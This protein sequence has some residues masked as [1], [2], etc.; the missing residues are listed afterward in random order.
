MKDDKKKKFRSHGEIDLHEPEELEETEGAPELPKKAARADDEPSEEAD[1]SPAETAGG[2]DENAPPEDDH[3]LADKQ[4]EQERVEKFFASGDGDDGQPPE[5]PKEPPYSGVPFWKKLPI[6]YWRHRRWT[7]PLTMLIILVVLAAI[8]AVRYSVLSHYV[9]K[10]YTVHVADRQTGRPVE[11]AT[12]RLGNDTDSTD[13][14]GDVQVAAKVGQRHLTINRKYYHNFSTQVFVNLLGN[15]N[16]RNIKLAATGRQVPFTV[17]D[18]L[19]GQPIKNATI[20]VL[21]TSGETDKNGKAVIVLPAKNLTLRAHISAT[22]YNGENADVSVTGSEVVANHL[23]LTPSGKVYFLSNRSG[24][25]DVISTNLDGSDRET[26]VRGTGN[27]DLGTTRLFVSPA[28]NQLVLHAK[29]DDSGAA[30]LYFYDGTTGGLA[31]LD[32]SPV[33]FNPYGWIGNHFIYQI[34]KLTVHDWQPKQSLLQS[35]NGNSGKTVTLDATSATGKS[36]AYAA[37]KFGFVTFVNGQVVY[38]KNW[39]SPTGSSKLLKNKHNAVFRVS[40]AGKRKNDLKDIDIPKGNNYTSLAAIQPLPSKLYIQSATL[41]QI[42]Y[43]IYQDGRVSQTNT[44]SDD[45]FAKHYPDYLISPN[46]KQSLWMETRDGRHLLFVGTGKNRGATEISGL[47]GYSPYAW[48]GNQ[49][50][51]ISKDNTLYILSIQNP[52][53]HRKPIKI[54]AYYSTGDPAQ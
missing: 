26:A 17:R 4:D 24:R 14:N 9:V 29:R 30:K 49:D 25:I 13:S 12:V 37:Q 2:Q 46:D 10:Q 41:S 51:I 27:E 48:Y 19:S 44:I 38:G 54:S 42:V 43:Y 34:K 1:T 11:D 20:E 53:K 22:G 21:D 3:E 52:Q 28:G 40:P 23:Q 39:I 6:K 47:R 5:P 15:Q 31:E 35:Y 36:G 18:K 8:P 32:S 45:A 7:I 16:R 33:D 50:I